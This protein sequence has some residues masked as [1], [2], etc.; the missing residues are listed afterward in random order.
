[1]RRIPGASGSALC[2]SELDLDALAFTF[3]QSHLRRCCLLASSPRVE[4]AASRLDRLSQHPISLGEPD[5]LPPTQ[6]VTQPAIPARLRRLTLQRAS[7]FLDLMDDVVYA[8]QVLLRS[9][10]LQLG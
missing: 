7:L 8:V 5:G 2:F 10:Q 9:L 4:P 6:L 1:M 3:D